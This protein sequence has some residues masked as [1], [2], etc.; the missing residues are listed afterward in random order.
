MLQANLTTAIA[1]VE[2][3]GKA[4]PHNKLVVKRLPVQAKMS[5]KNLC[6]HPTSIH[7]RLMG[8]SG[9]AESRN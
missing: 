6:P 9:L 1:A 5:E 2:T 8:S 4:S 7:T 3:N